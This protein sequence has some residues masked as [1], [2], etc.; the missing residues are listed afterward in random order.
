MSINQMAVEEL[1]TAIERYGLLTIVKKLFGVGAKIQM[2]FSESVCD[3]AVTA[4]N[5]SVRSVNCLMKAGLKTV[6]H[7]IDAIHEDTLLKI[8]NLGHNSR[9]EIRM[10]VCEFGYDQLSEKGR[11][12]FVQNLIELNK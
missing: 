5:L 10:R 2:P 4:L 3:T 1:Y 7:V 11:K 9:A 8:R 12:Q 6:E